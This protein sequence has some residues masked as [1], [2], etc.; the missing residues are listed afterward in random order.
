MSL[1][2]DSITKLFQNLLISSA[3]VFLPIVLAESAFRC[4]RHIANKQPYYESSSLLGWKPRTNVR[5]KNMSV[6]NQDGLT[7]HVDYST[8]NHGFRFSDRDWFV[9]IEKNSPRL[10]VIGDSFTA[11]PYTSD[12]DAWF[13][14]IHH[15]L[16]MKVYA[17]G[18]G[19]SGTFQQTLA[20]KEVLKTSKP[21]LI[22]LQACLNDIS[23]NDPA[24][25]FVSPIRNQVLRRPYLSSAGGS[26]VAEGY[27]P[28]IYRALFANSQLFAYIDNQL[29]KK[30]VI[31]PFADKATLHESTATLRKHGGSPEGITRAA[32]ELFAVTA[33]S[34]NPEV[35][36]YSVMCSS[37]RPDSWKKIFTAAGFTYLS[38][39]HKVVERAEAEG[40]VVRIKDGAHWNR[41]GNK[42]FGNAVAKSL[43][44][45]TH[46]IRNQRSI[47]SP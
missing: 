9:D 32:L 31:L 33:R 3:S 42:L 39:P 25:I 38:D 27:Y 40:V 17:Y 29:A 41:T 6:Q 34:F 11:E 36:L 47:V 26:F 14:Y 13:A 30:G 21:D 43:K 5:I 1:L 37:P 23:D 22:I 15:R 16:H 19:G 4:F 10:L 8:D 46:L 2:P 24:N 12:R 35:K 18:I 28:R 45:E 20:L 44:N 7:Y